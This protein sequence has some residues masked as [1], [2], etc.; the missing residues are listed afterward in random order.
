MGLIEYLRN[1]TRKEPQKKNEKYIL[2][3]DGGGTRG[4]IPATILS[5]LEEML[6]TLGLSSRITDH[7][8][9]IAGTSTGGLI[10]LALTVP[11]PSYFSVPYG[12][13]G[14]SHKIASLYREES[15]TIFPKTLPFLST[16]FINQLFNAKYE[17]DS[18]NELLSRI[19][20]SAQ[21]EEAVKPT[22][23]VTYDYMNDRPHLL[24]SWDYP[25]LSMK[26][27]ARA[28]C[29]AP[30]YFT[31]A[32]ID[33]H[34]HLID[35]GVVANNPILYA[36]SEAKKLFPETDTFHILSLS[37]GSV[38]N[39]IEYASA[40]RGVL[41]WMDPTKG[42]PLYRLYASSQMR[43]ADMMAESLSD[44]EYLRIH[45]TKAR[46]IRLDETDAEVLSE[47]T[48]YAHT[49][50]GEYEEKIRAFFLPLAPEAREV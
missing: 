41:S 42:T 8:D 20:S 32:V 29:A 31:P 38:G 34:L 1:R 22:M 6:P 7:F 11:D 12:M 43:T 33:S 16:G 46:R 25:S 48:A 28:T 50:W 23:V 47:M 36:Y 17:D 35:G 21:L 39:S 24:S 13:S 4:V 30:T 49:L 44:V 27:A 45:N 18:F 3:I 19:F 26:K 5:R 40:N 37:T 15:S 9:L 14:R 10:A 2:T